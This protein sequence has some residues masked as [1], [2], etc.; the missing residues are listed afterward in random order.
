MPPSTRTPPMRPLA[1]GVVLVLL[2]VLCGAWITLR[3]YA[4]LQGMVRDEVQLRFLSGRLLHLR[5]RLAQSARLAVETGQPQWPARYRQ[6]QPQFD[7][8]LRQLVAV[9]PQ[10]SVMDS[11]TWAASAALLSAE[12]DA[13]ALVELG[14]R[15][16]ALALLT[17]REY[18]SRLIAYEEGLAAM[19][20]AAIEQ[21]QARLDEQRRQVFTAAL[22]GLVL[23]ALLA[24]AWA[25]ISGLVQ[26][27]LAA[28]QGAEAALAEANHELE[29]RVRLRTAELSDANQQLRHEMTQRTK[30]ELE[31][32]QAQKLEAVGRLAAGVAHEINTPVQFVNDSCH[33]LH[34]GLAATAEQI[35]HCR[36]ALAA[37]AR[38]QLTPE[39]AG[40]V[41]ARLEQDAPYFAQHMPQASA[42]ALEGL[43]RIAQIVRSMKEFSHPGARTPIPTDLNR[44]IQSTLTV[45]RSEYKYVADVHTD[46]GELPLVYCYPGDLNQAMLN[47]VVN[48]AHA[49]AD[50]AP[51]SERRGC[52]SVRTRTEEGD[53]VIEIED[54][55]CGIPETLRE[56]IFEPFFTTKEVGRGTGQ[57]LAITWAI[58][59]E[60]H[61]GRIEVESAPGRGSRFTIRIP[62]VQPEG[63]TLARVA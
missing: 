9:A 50:V 2:L 28:V 1:A 42:R 10:R 30:M 55:G 16:G 11:P 41:L 53:A 60:R 4:D 7:E 58:V 62:L 57:G 14:E 26:R 6:T 15:P 8:A 40:R 33:F 32:R 21:A 17:G 34:D 22:L 12:N 61:H 29:R 27:Y 54:D 19:G 31:L 24:A 59:V 23:L 56:R 18:E 20:D 63:A 43:E 49:I 44:A 37:A 38:S 5:E 52:I 45:A 39:E 48:A 13:L 51:G 3:S 25:W 35:E 46:F 36:Q 47:L